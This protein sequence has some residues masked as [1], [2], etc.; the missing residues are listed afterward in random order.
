MGP[1]SQPF[2]RTI[3]AS[4]H[5]VLAPITDS[6]NKLFAHAANMRLPEAV[7]NSQV[8]T[9]R[10]VLV[11]LFQPLRPNYRPFSDCHDFLSSVL[12]GLVKMKC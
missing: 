9:L 3:E 7:L 11:D 1:C 10:P 8:S 4:P 2:Q 5:A 12:K 6:R